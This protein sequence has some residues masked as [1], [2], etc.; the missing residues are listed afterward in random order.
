MNNVGGIVVASLM[1]VA[2]GKNGAAPDATPPIDAPSAIDAI[3]PVD[4]RSPNLVSVVVYDVSTALPSSGLPVAFLAADGSPIMET[5]TDANGTAMAS[6]PAGGSVTIGANSVTGIDSVPQVTT[7]LDV[8]PGDQLELNSSATTTYSS[9]FRISAPALQGATS[10]TFLDSCGTSATG[11]DPSVMYG[12]SSYLPNQLPCTAA[13]FLVIANGTTPT[14]TLFS[15]IQ[16]VVGFAVL[17]GSYAPPQSTSVV[18]TGEPDGALG[19]ASVTVSLLAGDR[20]LFD[21]TSAFPDDVNLTSV[22]LPAG[23]PYDVVSQLT[24][25]DTSTTSQRAIDRQ[26][27]TT[28]LA[29]DVSSERLPTTSQAAFDRQSS[30]ITWSETGAGTADAESASLLITSTDGTSRDYRWTILARYTTDRLALPTLPS[31][32]ATFNPSSSDQIVVDRLGLIGITG[33]YD[34]IRA[35]FFDGQS[36]PAPGRLLLSGTF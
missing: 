30:S 11:T 36:M 2:C 14:Q 13:S 33:G 22:D 9:T 28:S 21:A 15:P 31:S 34:A 10:Y 18:M 6:M 26:L 8:Q 24:W 5:T 32:L 4:A 16:P 3:P 35:R 20:N 29:I 19:P 17:S 27:A 7:W 23:T 12:T 25:S 1:M